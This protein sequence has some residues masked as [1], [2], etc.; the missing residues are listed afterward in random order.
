MRGR[1]SLDIELVDG[2]RVSASV[3][4]FDPDADLVLLRSSDVPRTDAAPWATTPPTAGMLAIAVSHA[5]GQVAVAPVFVMAAPDADRRVRTTSTSLPP[6]TPLFTTAGEVFAIA[7]GGN[8]PSASLIAPAVAR[9]RERIASGQARRGAL[10][11]TF[12]PIDAT[13]Q[14]VFTVPGVLV[15]DLAVSGPAADGGVLPGDI[16]T[17]IGDTPVTSP[18]SAR[19]AIAALSPQHTVTL[20]LFRSGKPMSIQTVTTSALGLRVRHSPRAPAD[21]A[22]EARAVFDASVRQQLGLLADSR[23]LAVNGTPV[24]TVDD[25][26]QVMRRARGPLA[27]YVEDQRGRLFCVVERSQ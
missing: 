3:V 26:H 12:Q 13:L 22:L 4:A 18:E 14:K 9:L 20:Q 27:V 19:T 25:V 21:D 24:E 15:A 16:I 11:L 1:E 7:A 6:G 5:G 2:R 8:D 10:G 23:I 17:T